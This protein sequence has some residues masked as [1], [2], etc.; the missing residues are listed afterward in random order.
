MPLRNWKCF[1]PIYTLTRCVTIS[2][3]PYCTKDLVRRGTVG[4]GHP[5]D[6]YA[7]SLVSNK[8]C[9][10]MKIMVTDSPPVTWSI[11]GERGLE[12]ESMMD[13]INHYKNGD[14]RLAWKLTSCITW[15]Q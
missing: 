3:L 5:R 11:V 13:L 2:T 1:I 15:K 7:L 6:G 9:F 12:F 4:I 10:H 14:P 8:T